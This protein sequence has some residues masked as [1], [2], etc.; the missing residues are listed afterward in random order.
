MWRMKWHNIC[1]VLLQK[2][3]QR[4]KRSERSGGSESCVLF[5]GKAFDFILPLPILKFIMWYILCF[6]ICRL[7]DKFRRMHKCGLIEVFDIVNVVFWCFG[8]KPWAVKSFIL[9]INVFG[10]HCRPLGTCTWHMSCYFINQCL[11]YVF[12]SSLICIICRMFCSFI[13]CILSIVEPKNWILSA[14]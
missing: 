3:K 14:G 6:A 12:S 1:V 7:Y 9:H 4:E 2:N 13:L 10:C 11:C 8:Y 5:S